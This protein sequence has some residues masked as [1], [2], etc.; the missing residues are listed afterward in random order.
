LW[1]RRGRNDDAMHTQ[2]TRIY[3]KKV[4]RISKYLLG[5]DTNAPLGL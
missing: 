1:T 4:T 2:T 3:S 5:N